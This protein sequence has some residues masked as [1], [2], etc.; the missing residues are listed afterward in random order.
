MLALDLISTTAADEVSLR[1]H[2]GL[3]RILHQIAPGQA[4]IR[5]IDP[6]SQIL[7]DLRWLMDNA[8]TV[9]DIELRAHLMDLE[10]ALRLDP[11]D[12]PNTLRRLEGLVQEDPTR[13]NS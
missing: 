5:P 7:K 6:G 12:L 3:D 9:N 13:L 8:T 11:S 2:D 4:Y 10:A 1:G